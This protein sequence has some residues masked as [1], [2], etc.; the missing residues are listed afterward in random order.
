MGSEGPTP[1]PCLA[2]TRAQGAH[3]PRASLGPFWGGSLV[4]LS[5]PH[6]DQLRPGSL[7]PQVP[8]PGEPAACSAST[9]PRGDAWLTPRPL[10]QQ[11]FQPPG[12]NG[13]K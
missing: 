3:F 5:F 10:Q 1:T 2:H 6:Q 7:S 11:G 13:E 4:L 8:C 9:D 12:F